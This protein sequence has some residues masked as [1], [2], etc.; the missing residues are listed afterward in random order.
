MTISI[1]PL[2]SPSHLNAFAHV[3]ALAFAESPMSRAM[4]PPPPDGLKLVEDWYRA[5][6]ILAM[7]DPSQKFFAVVKELDPSDDDENVDPASCITLPSSEE[8]C[9]GEQRKR[10][11]ILACAKWSRL[12]LSDQ[13]NEAANGTEAEQPATQAGTTEG[14][15]ASPKDEAQKLLFDPN[16]L[17]KG[18]NVELMKAF[19]AGLKEGRKK[20]IDEEK[21]SVLDLLC[22]NPVYQRQGLGG[23]LLE[24]CI[25]LADAANVRVF[26][27]ATKV[28]LPLYKRYGWEPVGKLEWRLEDYGVQDEGDG[29]GKLVLTQMIRE[30]TRK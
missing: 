13:K 16:Y 17:P 12:S 28:G 21:D 22:T 18:S 8:A 29:D 5:R 26:L 24:L 10:Y 6:E 3:K 7:K 25:K 30:P 9:D 23:K 4:Y 20:Y 11:V 14:T 27:E 15:N 2:T 19:R 1:I